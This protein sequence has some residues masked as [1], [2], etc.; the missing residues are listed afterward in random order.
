MR[1]LLLATTAF[2]LLLAS[3]T[4]SAAYVHQDYATSGDGLTTL[5]Q[6]T[7]I[8]W[9][10]LSVTKGMSIEQV[11]AKMGAGGLFDGWRFPTGEEVESVLGAIVPI[12]LNNS[13]PNASTTSTARLPYEPAWTDWSTWFGKTYN[14]SSTSF[15]FGL[16]IQNVGSGSKVLMSGMN[17]ENSNINI[18]DDNNGGY[19]TSMSPSQKFGVF[20]VKNSTPIVTPPSDVPAPLAS[21]GI[22]LGAIL[23]GYR[24]KCKKTDTLASN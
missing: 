14:G 16:Y 6:S 18:Y 19:S 20:L 1:H 11:A 8:E 10:K 5:D 13:T 23:F 15:S 12:K 9:L 21:W 22:G 3:G 17:I 24:R 2:A 7:G 4:A